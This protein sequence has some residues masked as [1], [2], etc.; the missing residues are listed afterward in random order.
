MNIQ[1]WLKK[2][3][4]AWPNNAPEE[5]LYEQISRIGGCVECQRHPPRFVKRKEGD[6]FV[7]IVCCYCGQG[8]FVVPLASFAQKS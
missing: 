3:E 8:Y 7:N 4:P 1:N 6:I 2:L 5:T